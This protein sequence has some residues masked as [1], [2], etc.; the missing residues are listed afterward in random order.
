MSIS[1]PSP[2][3]PDDRPLWQSLLRGWKGACPN[4]GRGR[5]FGRYL[6]V[7]DSCGGCGTAFHHHQSDDAP[8]Y[9][10]ILIVGHVVLP[11]LVMTERLLHP[12]MWIQMALWP[13]VTLALTLLLLPRTK[14]AVIALQWSRRMHGFSDVAEAR[15]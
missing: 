2:D 6:K 1:Y 8:P 15:T 9:F 11:G 10:T 13:A 4:C 7:K 14:G 12:E 5:L 3:T